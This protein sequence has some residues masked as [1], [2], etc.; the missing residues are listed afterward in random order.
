MGLSGISSLKN[1]QIF[2][3]SLSLYLFESHCVVL[4]S[5]ETL[6]D[7]THPIERLRLVCV[8]FFICL[9]RCVLPLVPYASFKIESYRSILALMVVT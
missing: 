7:G 6:V 1:K 2:S 4:L 3:Y 8:L 5:E 9:L